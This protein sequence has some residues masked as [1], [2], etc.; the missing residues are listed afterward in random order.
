[1][2]NLF[3]K[4]KK[5]VDRKDLISVVCCMLPFVAVRYLLNNGYTYNKRKKRKKDIIKHNNLICLLSPCK[6]Y[7][8]EFYPDDVDYIKIMFLLIEK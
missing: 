6:R 4:I 5:Y 2:N 8:F 7:R 3:N 1:M